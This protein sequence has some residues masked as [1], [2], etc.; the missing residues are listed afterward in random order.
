MEGYIGVAVALAGGMLLLVVGVPL[1][2]RAIG[3]NRWYGYRIQATLENERVW[4]GVNAQTGRH[5]VVIGALLILCGL[6]GLGALNAPRQQEMLVAICVV[7]LVL[8]LG[9]S[10]VSGYRT[11]REM[12]SP[13]TTPPH[14][15]GEDAA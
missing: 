2:R 7:I 5:L 11:A 13:P 1:A 12:P 6:V 10:I 4:Y 15:R 14:G 3:P 8:G 9:Y